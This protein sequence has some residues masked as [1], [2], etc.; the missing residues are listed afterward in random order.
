MS[1]RLQSH[2]LSDVGLVRTNNEDAWLSSP[3]DQLFLLADGLG[4]HQS[5]EVAA[6]EAIEF[7]N[8]TYCEWKKRDTDEPFT[9]HDVML[10]LRIC[11]EKTNDHLFE[12][13][14]S[15]ELLRGMG[16]TFCSL[17]F[18]DEMVAVSHVGDSR[19]YRL[20]SNTLEQIT[21]DHCWTKGLLFSPPVGFGFSKG[22]LTRAL[23][24]MPKVEP[25]VRLLTVQ[26]RDIFLLCSDGLSDMVSHVEIEDIL[27]RPL[28]IGERVRML[29]STAK[30][31]GGVDNITVILVEVVNG[32][33]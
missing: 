9:E 24:T 6:R 33:S 32:L 15:H 8:D 12:L 25:T 14:C 20:R 1:L 16:T 5:G 22:V 23:G 2:G 11:F 30:N 10:G 28:T 3:E 7:F 31:N 21:R 17:S 13:A 29:V 18:Y 27:R 26:H 19:V 4:G